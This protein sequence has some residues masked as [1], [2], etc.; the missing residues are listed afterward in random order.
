MSFDGCLAEL[1]LLFW[2][3]L[4]DVWCHCDDILMI[5]DGFVDDIGWV[6]VNLFCKNCDDMLMSVHDVWGHC[7]DMLMIVDDCVGDICWVWWFV[8]ETN[9]ND[10]LMIV[11]DFYE[12][13]MICWWY[14]IILL[15]TFDEF[16]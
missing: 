2:C 14:L 16:W 4:I 15:I 9:F 6:L 13:M 3:V 5:F 10:M 8:F 1:A 7:D 11:D 12:M